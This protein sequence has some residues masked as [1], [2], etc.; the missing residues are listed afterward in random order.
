MFDFFGTILGWLQTLANFIVS[1]VE[2]L[3][4]AI[5]ALSA[6]SSLPLTLVSYMPAILGASITIA[7]AVMVVKFLI[8][9]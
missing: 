5:V 9:R 8:G 1:L 4:L 3:I 7:V 2:S 6:S